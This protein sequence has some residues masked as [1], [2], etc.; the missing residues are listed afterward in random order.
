VDVRVAEDG[1]CRAWRAEDG[2]LT[3][4]K[5]APSEKRVIQDLM[6]V[7]FIGGDEL[8]HEYIERLG[9]VDPESA[10][11]GVLLHRGR[12]VGRWKHCRRRELRQSPPEPFPAQIREDAEVGGDILK[13]HPAPPGEQFAGYDS[14]APPMAEDFGVAG[15]GH[16]E[17][18]E[19]ADLFTGGNEET[20]NLVGSKA[21][22]AVPAEQVGALGLES[23]DGVDEQRG[24]LLHGICAPCFHGPGIAKDVE[25]LVLAKA[26]GELAEVVWV[27]VGAGDAEEGRKGTVA[28]EGDIGGADD[29]GGMAAVLR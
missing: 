11:V 5:L 6:P 26:L 20:R 13:A 24:R 4:N 16:L 15:D 21:P 10:K 12:S 22:K 8:S 2:E 28:L 17:E 18:D 27:F 25:G 14:V 9:G 1:I 23:S 29:G 7:R 3:A 19:T